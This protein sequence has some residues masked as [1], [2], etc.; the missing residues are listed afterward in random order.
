MRRPEKKRKPESILWLPLP[1]AI[2][3]FIEQENCFYER[4]NVFRYLDNGTKVF[5]YVATTKKKALSNYPFT[6]PVKI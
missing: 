5:E 6:K 2:Y 4:T 3:E 1:E